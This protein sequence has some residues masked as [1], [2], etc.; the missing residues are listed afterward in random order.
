LS[1]PRDCNSAST[2]SLSAAAQL[3]HMLD[4]CTDD[5]HSKSESGAGAMPLKPLTGVHHSS[6]KRTR[7]WPWKPLPFLKAGVRTVKAAA[8]PPRRFCELTTI[9][10][11]AAGMLLPFLSNRRHF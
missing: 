1:L 6:A 5:E 3:F 9:M 2:A 10:Q 8:V 7:G 4:C 11:R